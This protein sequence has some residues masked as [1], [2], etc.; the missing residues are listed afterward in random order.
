MTTISQPAKIKNLSALRNFNKPNLSK[1]LALQRTSNCYYYCLISQQQTPKKQ[2]I[3]IVCS[4]KKQQLCTLLST[5]IRI[6]LLLIRSK[7]IIHQDNCNNPLLLNQASK[8]CSKLSKPTRKYYASLRIMHDTRVHNTKNLDIE[9]G[10]ECIY[11][12]SEKIFVGMESG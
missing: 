4:N 10:S 8:W 5:R 11:R 7:T 2:K 6:I 3:L 12:H 9:K 1:C